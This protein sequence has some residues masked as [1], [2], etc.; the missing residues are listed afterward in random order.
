VLD[1][2]G[3]LSWNPTRREL[4][5]IE[6]QHADDKKTIERHGGVRGEPLDDGVTA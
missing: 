1:S 4:E 5:K 6:T 3:R 2:Y